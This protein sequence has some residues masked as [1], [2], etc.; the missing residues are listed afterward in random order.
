MRIFDIGFYDGKD[1]GYF[2]ERGFEVVAFEANPLLYQAGLRKFARAIRSGRLQLLNLGIG[3][4]SGEQVDFFV[5][6]EYDE[7]STFY[8]EAAVNWGPGKSRVVKVPCITPQ[9]MFLRFG[10]PDY[11]K[12]DIEGFDI[13]V[14]ESLQ[15]LP[16]KPAIVAFEASNLGLLRALL[17]AGYQSFKLVDQQRVPLQVVHDP[18]TGRTFKFRGG[19]GPLGDDAE[20]E[21][22]SFE[23]VSYLYFRFVLDPFGSCT[24]PDHWFDIH[25]SLQPPSP[26]TMQR[27]YLRRVIVETYGGYC[28]MR[29]SDIKPICPGAELN[30]LAER[31]AEIER[32]RTQL[33][34]MENSRAWKVA[35]LLRRLASPFKR[36]Y[37][38]G[39]Q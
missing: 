13:L 28:G 25:A 24:P 16:D 17:L 12:C 8:R 26:D 11:L 36:F 30:H 22:L 14:A 9:E 1:T 38:P 4:E 23:N 34:N 27:E 5:H 15:G 33:A 18:Q 39:S 3:A 2:V 20:G 7:W 32:L 10:C 21:W 31:T 29:T 19:A 6:T 35:L 37:A